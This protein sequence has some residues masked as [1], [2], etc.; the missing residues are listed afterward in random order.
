MA[1][2]VL[3]H[4][5][6]NRYILK[7]YRPL[8]LLLICG[9]VCERLIYNSMYEYFIRKDLISPNQP[10][11]KPVES[12]TNQLIYITHATYQSFDDGFEIRGGFLKL[13]F[14]YR[15]VFLY[16][17]LLTKFGIMVLFIN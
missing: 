2:V 16:I 6:S 15:G 17:K 5:K 14:L 9:K 11:F 1:I 7:N 4:K 3:V 8:Y 12:N 13:V 10:G